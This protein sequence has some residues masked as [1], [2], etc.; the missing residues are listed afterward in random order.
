[1]EYKKIINLLDNTPNQPTKFRTKNWVEINVE[2]QGMYNKGNRIIF[3]TSMLRSS[4]YNYSNAFILVK[5]TITVA[6]TAVQGQAN[7]GA[8]EKTLFKNCAPFI[9]CIN[10]INNAQVDG[11]SYIDVVMPMYNLTKYSENYLKTSYKTFYIDVLALDDD[12]EITDFTEA[13]A[14]T[15]SFNLKVKLTGQTGNNTT[16]N[17]KLMVSLRYLSKFWRIIEMP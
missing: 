16:K 6:N 12:G 14:T 9:N 7:N 3:K 15:E 11:A 13:N 10:R 5:E 8:N 2:S 1:M 17:V 4:L